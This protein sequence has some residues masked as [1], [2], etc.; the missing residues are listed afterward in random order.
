MSEILVS[1]TITWREILRNLFLILAFTVA[2]VGSHSSLAN[3][4]SINGTWSGSGYV[5]PSNGKRETV[6][7]KVTY[8]QQSA[9]VYGVSA[10][11][12][13]PSTKIRQ[14]GEVLMVN[15]NRYVGDFYNSDFDISG[16]VNVSISG[17]NQTVSFKS[18][19]GH[20]SLSLSKR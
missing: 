8:S 16:R 20:G 2:S 19:S 9:K 14:T 7:C 5:Q 3:A 12:A 18:G 17:N 1:S 4:A 11:C 6:R 10:V 15:P 13:S